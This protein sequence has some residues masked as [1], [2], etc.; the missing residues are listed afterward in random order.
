MFN[1]RLQLI[2]NCS[3]GSLQWRAGLYQLTQPPS[4]PTSESRLQY[5]PA[6]PILQAG[7]IKDL[8]FSVWFVLPRDVPNARP[9]VDAK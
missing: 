4:E 8:L 9:A 1:A 5:P 3:S 7:V 6:L 2:E